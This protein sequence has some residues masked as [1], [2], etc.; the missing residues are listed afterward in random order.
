MVSD[1]TDAALLRFSTGD[2]PDRERLPFWRDFFAREIAH[3]DIQ[4]ISDVPF[5]AE[6][7]L[8]AWPELGAQWIS[9]SPM[10]LERTTKML[11]DGDDSLVLL[12]G[13]SSRLTIKQRGSEI[14]LAAAEAVALLR[15]E[16]AQ[17]MT[18][19]GNRLGV[20]IPR[21]SLAPLVS[22]VE[23]AA[24]RLIPN[25]DESLRLLITYI[26]MLRNQTP[27]TARLRHLTATHICDLVAM[28][29][30]A[31]RDAT[32]LARTRGNRAARLQAVLTDILIN[33]SDPG[34]TVIQVALRQGVT[35]RYIHKILEAEG[36]TF[37]E[38]VLSARLGRAHRMLTDSRFAS[39]SITEIAF[40]S[41]FGDL[42]YFDH[43]F[44]RR[45]GATPSEVRQNLRQP[46]E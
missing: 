43:A 26:G 41:G 18:E 10:R 31:S 46:D 32:E 39:L 1:K 30:G 13:S 37:S 9:G 25:H 27:R 21:A 11:A 8:L 35:P 16:P 28:A 12:I 44:R 38:H 14:L 33:A 24:M 45:F 22:D 19:G 29:V 20:V 4:P 23:S 3:V 17:I 7:T 6:A 2:L 36:S 42:S 15:A 34:L 40:A 5:H